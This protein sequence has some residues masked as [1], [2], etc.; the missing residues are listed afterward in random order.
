MMR[1]FYNWNNIHYFQRFIEYRQFRESSESS[2]WMWMC[3]CS[4]TLNTVYESHIS[5]S[6]SRS[7]AARLAPLDPFFYYYNFSVSVSFLFWTP[8]PFLADSQQ[9]TLKN[10]KYCF[11]S[12]TLKRIV[13]LHRSLFISWEIH[14]AFAHPVMEEYIFREPPQQP[15]QHK[16]SKL[17]MLKTVNCSYFQYQNAPVP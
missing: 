12:S 10:C 13:V 6:Y 7:H 8:P 4:P 5:C 2:L 11:Q 1:M 17:Y 15:N 3:L 16:M 14:K 9:S